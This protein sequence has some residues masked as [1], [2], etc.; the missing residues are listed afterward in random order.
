[1]A[2]LRDVVQRLKLGH[3]VRDIC[4]STGVHRTIIRDLR[5]L[6]H[7]NGWL[8]PEAELPSE[9]QIEAARMAQGPEGQPKRIFEQLEAFAEDFQ[10]W[11]EQS[12]TAV[13]MHDLV[14]SRVPCSLSTIDR[15]L[16]RRFPKAVDSTTRR[17]TAAGQVMEVDF[18]YLGL[19]F[20]PAS[21]RTRRTWVFSGRL[22]HCRRAWRERCY[23]Q[24]QQTFF[25]CHIHA[26]EFFGGVPAR[27][28]PDNLKA[29]VV[30]ASFQDPIVNRAYRA[31]AEHYGFLIDPCAP[32]R[33]QHKGGVESDIKY[34]KGNFWPIFR[35]RDRQRGHEVPFTDELQEALERWGAEVADRRR[36]GGVGRRPEEIWATEEADALKPLA[37]RRWDP[38]SWAA[39]KVGPDWRVQFEKGFY[40]VPYAH[41]GHPVLVY[42]DRTRVRI[43]AGVRE[44]ALHPRV[45]QPWGKSIRPEHAPP[46]LQEWLEADRSGLLRW[47]SRLGAP[48]G[49]VAEAIL[50]DQAVDGLRPLR[51][52]IGL[53]DRYST[54]RLAA[55]CRRALLYETP[56]FRSVKEILRAGLDRLPLSQPAVTSGQIAFRFQ[57]EPGYFDP[58][59]HVG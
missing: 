54:E 58:A 46:H 20:D 19:T 21:G 31:L 4:R 16:R 40:S 52:L 42:G 3:G 26:F 29:A 57:R 44:I 27:V 38:L 13:V 5:D 18:G 33:P 6:A 48:I 41:I 55:A 36:V 23:D 39:A 53:A 51:A 45:E 15:Y 28:V 47:A 17:D 30:A 35:E 1:M 12:Y 59:R 8:E 25:V 7:R 22:R 10:R 43:Y 37:R 11:H 24:K 14:R 34:I 50:S 9:P 56:T 49:E 32:Y 2:E